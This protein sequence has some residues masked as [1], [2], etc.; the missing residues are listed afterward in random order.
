MEIQDIKQ[1]LSLE[2]ILPRWLGYVDND[3]ADLQS[4]PA[5]RIK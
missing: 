1:S 2:S 3:S 5:K 4:V